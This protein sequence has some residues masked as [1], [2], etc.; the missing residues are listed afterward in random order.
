MTDCETPFPAFRKIPRLSKPCVITEKIDGTNA[1]IHIERVPWGYGPECDDPMALV[2]QDE[3]EHDPETLFPLYQYIVRAGSRKRWISPG[4][5]N[6]GFAAFVHANAQELIKL[7]PGHHYGEWH[8]KGI[9]RGYGLAEKRFAL[10]NV[11]RWMDV[12]ATHREAYLADFPTATPVPDCVTVVP[13][14]GMCDGRDLNY[15]ANEALRTLRQFGTLVNGA[16]GHAEGI[17]IFHTAAG[18]LFKVLAEN[19]EIPKSFAMKV[20]A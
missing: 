5:D 20:A 7:G 8:G 13:N 14:L 9:Q 17:V 6:Y 2:V 3:S 4:N 15:R 19:D 10:F 16:S 11:A 18:Q 12:N 1:L